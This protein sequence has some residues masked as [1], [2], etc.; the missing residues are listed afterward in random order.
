MKFIYIFC[1]LISAQGIYAAGNNCKN[2]FSMK[3]LESEVQRKTQSSMNLFMNPLQE[4]AFQKQW[5]KK[6]SAPNPLQTFL[7]KGVY[8]LNHQLFNP[9]STTAVKINSNNIVY[10]K[11]FYEHNNHTF[12][13]NVI[14]HKR[15]IYNNLTADKKYLAGENARAVILFLHGMGMKT[16]GEHIAKKWITDFSPYNIDVISLGLPWHSEGRRSFVTSLTEEVSHLSAFA[17][18]YIPPNTPLFILAHSGGTV[19]AQQ[20]MVLTDGPQGGRFFHPSLKGIILISPVVDTEPGKSANQKYQTFSAGQRKGLA[21]EPQLPIKPLEKQRFEDI[22]PLGELYGMW[23]ITQL[24]LNAPAHE[25]EKYTPALMAVGT[26]DPLVFTGFPRKVYDYYN[27]LKNMETHYLDKLPLLRNKNETAEVG[28]FISEYLD[29]SSKLPIA[30]ALSLQF[31]EKQLNTTLTKE[32]SGELFPDFVNAI[33]KFSNDLGFQRFI[34]IHKNLH[35]STNPRLISLIKQFKTAKTILKWEYIPSEKDLLK[36][37]N[38]DADQASQIVQNYI[39][40]ISES[41]KEYNILKRNI[42]RLTGIIKRKQKEYFNTLNRVKN[43]VNN[44]KKTLRHIHEKE[45][46]AGLKKDFHTLT[47]QLTIAQKAS[48]KAVY[49]FEKASLQIKKGEKLPSNKEINGILNQYEEEI[50][51]FKSAYNNYNTHREKSKWKLIKAISKGKLVVSTENLGGLNNEQLQESVREIYGKD[52]HPSTG[53]Q[54]VLYLKLK[55]QHEELM[56]IK[57]EQ[58]NNKIQV[59]GQLENYQ[60]IFI[61]LLKILKPVEKDSIDWIETAGQAYIFT[62]IRTLN[63]IQPEHIHHN[64]REYEL[65]FNSA[66]SAWKNLQLPDLPVLPTDSEVI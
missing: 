15:T 51:H 50:N 44:I 30:V 4:Q 18:K 52:P 35:Y 64:L 21:Q 42:T 29:P 2:S 58:Y 17:R 24:E 10:A 60:N 3:A 40:Q 1:I 63:D 11:A 48:N 5:E 7:P 38:A 31:M 54:G 53:A 33:Q 62:D 12:S 20:L 25:G 28:H 9:E 46:P 61:D 41:I 49:L 43:A 66:L 55:E 19:F 23:A 6:T 14:F 47:T 36:R 8:Y 57:E 34:T 22:S 16:A 27:K 32:A 13:T 45:L 65:F 37:I 26:K 59:N 39:T 56:Q